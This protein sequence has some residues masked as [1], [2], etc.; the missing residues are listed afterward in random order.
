MINSKEINIFLRNFDDEV[1]IFQ[2][3]NLN[4]N[5]NNI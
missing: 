5:I 2:N 1:S 3:E 4:F